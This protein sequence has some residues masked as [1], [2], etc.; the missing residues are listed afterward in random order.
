MI[1]A[2]LHKP[3]SATHREVLVFSF[4]PVIQAELNE[5]MRTWNCRNIRKSTEAPGGVPEMLF[6]VPAIA[7]FPKKGTNFSERDIQIAEET[8]GIAQYPTYFDKDI[9]ELIIC[10]TRINKLTI[11]RDSE[12][13]LSFYINILECFEKD[14]FPV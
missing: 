5:F 13:V 7:G 11:A 4:I 2:N 3:S 14:G 1:N 9:Y 8:L 12:E 10:Y 6:N